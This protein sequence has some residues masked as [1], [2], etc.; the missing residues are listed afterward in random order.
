MTA[1]TN[2]LRKHRPDFLFWGIT[3]AAMLLFLGLNPLWT[4]EDRWA[5]IVRE[6]RLTGD[7]IHPAINGV[8]YLDKPQLTYW[9]IAV[10]A[11][12]FALLDEF[13]IRLPSVLTALVA[14]GAL[15]M[16]GRKLYDDS[17]AR[18]A[19]WLL[20]GSY[21]FL[22]WS[23]L[24]QADVAN[25]AAITLAVA[26]FLKHADSRARFRDYFV[27]YAVCF[28]GALCKGLPALVM[29]FVVI[30]PFLWRGGCWKKHLC[31]E[32]FLA[33]IPAAAIYIL[34]LYLAQVLPYA[35]GTTPPGDGL[36]G[37]ELVWR[38]NIV[39]VFQPFDHDDEPFFCYLYQLPRC[40]AP[41]SLL[42]LAGIAGL[43][44]NWK[45]LDAQT[46]DLLIGTGLMFVLFSASGSR[47]WYYI[48]PVMPFALLLTARAL[49]G[50]GRENWNRWALALMRYAIIVC[51]S[52][53]LV[54][55][56][57]MPFWFRILNFY[58]P[59]PFLIGLPAMGA[60]TLL[61]MFADEFS[62]SDRL[63]GW[64]GMPAQLAAIVLGGTI[65]SCGFFST[66]FPSWGRMR[67]EKPLLTELRDKLPERENLVLWYRESLPKINF[68]LDLPRPMPVVGTAEQ[69]KNQM[70]KFAGRPWAI[71]TYTNTRY[72]RDL[73]AAAAVCGLKLNWE[74]PDFQEQ[75]Q[76]FAKPDV[77]GF[78]VWRINGKG[79]KNK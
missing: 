25:L 78:A 38:E 16:L 21:A 24:A 18:V 79:E 69:L 3:L 68:Y 5:E 50:A 27:F 10:I 47:R 11:W 67:T 61:V 44:A 77:R 7:W 75:R 57:L 60:L 31:K 59:W 66:L 55:L 74:K 19:A 4:S 51:A 28:A 45:K 2:M 43:L 52:A 23:R 54:S 48:M 49:T 58:P 41:W 36:S 37:W 71:I 53:G 30:A 26:W 6:M 35:P 20:L 29:P 34:P 14:L 76:I 15:L 65:L 40:L 17:T 33:L 13:L 62:N 56:M 1:W 64:T 73:K 12:P 72:F 32:N 22:F 42:A 46:R 39:R 63:S 8:V 9:L 70:E